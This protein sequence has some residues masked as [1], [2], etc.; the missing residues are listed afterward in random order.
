MDT[1]NGIPWLDDEDPLSLVG[2]YTRDLQ[3]IMAPAAATIPTSSTF[4]GSLLAVAFGPLVTITGATQRTG[5]SVSTQ[6]DAFGIVDTWAIPPR[7]RPSS[8][9]NTT[10]VM[11]TS[12][13]ISSRRFD[14]TITTTGRIVGYV[15]SESGALANSGW[16]KFSAIYPVT[17]A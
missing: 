3:E 14:C 6:G 9:M 13:N 11:M 16:L 2:Q 7:F 1:T 15:T 5:G 12:G 4:T 10:A 8:D 17:L